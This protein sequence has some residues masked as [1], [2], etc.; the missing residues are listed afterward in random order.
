[1]IIFFFLQQQFENH[2]LVPKVMERQVGV[3]PV[4]VII[5]LLIG[6]ALLGIVG[7]ILAI[8]TAAI[9]QVIIHELWPETAEG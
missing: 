8:P 2:I 1:V 5:S 7:A 6:G 3:S 9:L 4:T